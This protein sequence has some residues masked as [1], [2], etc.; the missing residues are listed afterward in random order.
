MQQCDTSTETYTTLAPFV[1][2]RTAQFTFIA[3]SV[4]KMIEILLFLWIEYS[5]LL[6]LRHASTVPAWGHFSE[7]PACINKVQI[8]RRHTHTH[9]HTHALTHARTHNLLFFL[10]GFFTFLFL[11]PFFAGVVDAASTI[12]FRSQHLMR[13]CGFFS[14]TT[15]SNISH[16]DREQQ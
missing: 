8:Q 2:C 1:N 10:F 3:F 5:P 11:F 13:P 6:P 12:W 15:Q 7:P 14:Q 16:T 9:T 4:L